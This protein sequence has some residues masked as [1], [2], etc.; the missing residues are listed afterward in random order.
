MVLAQ[1]ELKKVQEGETVP[2]G[3]KKMSGMNGLISRVIE[4]IG[5]SEILKLLKESFCQCH[6]CEAREFCS[7]KET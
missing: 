5:P 3:V 1:T 7:D 4:L 2:S 6:R